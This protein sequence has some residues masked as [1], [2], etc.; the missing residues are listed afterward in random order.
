MC[1]GGDTRCG[2]LC[3][4]GV[5]WTHPSSL[6]PD[7]T[8]SFLRPP[9]FAIDLLGLNLAVVRKVQTCFLRLLGGI[10][11]YR[12]KNSAPPTLRPVPRL[13]DAPVS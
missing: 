5:H 2:G 4:A 8:V 1:A 7:I 6:S 3:R 9:H 12:C 13:V 10:P 11:V